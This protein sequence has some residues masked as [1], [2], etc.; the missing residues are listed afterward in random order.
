MQYLRVQ[1]DKKQICLECANKIKKGSKCLMMST[2]LNDGTI[3]LNRKTN[4]YVCVECYTI[5][6]T[7]N[8]NKYGVIWE[9]LKEKLKNNPCVEELRKLDSKSLEKV[10]DFAK[11]NGINIQVIINEYNCLEVLG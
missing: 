10:V 3:I 1:K 8:L 11:K 5:I 6:K 4:F 2:V 7:F 9:E